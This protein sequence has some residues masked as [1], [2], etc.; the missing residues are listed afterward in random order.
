MKK[1]PHMTKQDKNGQIGSVF[2]ACAFAWLSGSLAVLAADTNTVPDMWLGDTSESENPSLVS[3]PL[4]EPGC[5]TISFAAQSGP[6]S[7][8]A[9][10]VIADAGIAESP[11][12]GDYSAAGALGVSFRIAGNGHSPRLSAV[13]LTGQQ[14]GRRWYNPTVTVSAA[15]GEWTT[16][17]ISFDLAAGWVMFPE[18]AGDLAAMWQQDLQD[19]GMIGVSLVQNGV[20]AQSYTLDEFRLVGS[21]GFITPP[22]GLSP[23]EQALADVFGGKTSVDQLT[24]EERQQDSNANGMTDVYEILSEN[25]P[26]FANSIFVAEVVPPSSEAVGV[27]VKWACVKLSRYTVYRSEDLLSVFHTL[28]DPSSLDIQA[29]ETG[30]MTYQDTSATG[31]GPYF[32]KVLKK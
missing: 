4:S 7:Y 27:T 3:F 8:V 16:N 17:T 15:T 14:S 9:A 24:D 29:V 22:A 23:L 12:S 26:A 32:Y 11:F 30:Y 19:V 21:D 13:M 25:D 2:A 10:G 18:V 31:A 28:A 5:I 6:P 20:D 1:G